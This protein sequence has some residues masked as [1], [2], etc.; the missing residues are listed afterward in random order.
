MHQISFIKS[1]GVTGQ[2]LGW[3]THQNKKTMYRANVVFRGTKLR[4]FDFDFDFDI[5]QNSLVAQSDQNIR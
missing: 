3:E 2:N 1:H 4:G 5:Y